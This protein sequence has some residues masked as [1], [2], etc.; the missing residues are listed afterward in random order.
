MQEAPQDI[1]KPAFRAILAYDPD[2]LFAYRSMVESIFRRE[3]PSKSKVAVLDSETSQQ[4]LS[5]GI[6]PDTWDASFTIRQNLAFRDTPA[7]RRFMETMGISDA[8]AETLTGVGT[9]EVGHWEFPKESG[10]G[11]PFDKPTYLTMFVEPVRGE[12]VRSGKFSAGALDEWSYR[13]A[14]AVTDIID[15]FHNATVLRERG[16]AYSGQTLFWYLQGESGRYSPEYSLFVKLNLA[17]FGN[18]KDNDLLRMFMHEAKDVGM[19]VKSLTRSFSPADENSLSPLLLRENWETIAR[20]YVREAL[21]YADLSDS[22]PKMAYSAGG[23]A[24]GQPESGQAGGQKHGGGKDGES[25][26]DGANAQ[27]GKVQLSKG[28]KEKIMGGRK[29][30]QGIPFYLDKTEA[31]DAYYS[32]LARRIPLKAA[33]KMPSAHLPLIPLTR[34]PYDPDVHDTRDISMGSVM[35]DRSRGIIA[36]SVTKS[37]MP[38]PIPVKREKKNLPDCMMVLLDSSGSMMDR[39]NTTIVPWGD[40]SFY[41]FGILAYYCQLRFFQSEHILHKMD[42]SGAIFSDRTLS[43]K[44]IDEV[45]RLIFNPMGGGTSL[46]MAKVMECLRSRHNILFSMISDGEIMNWHYIK[47]EFI[48][49]AKRNQFFM[50]QIGGMT[51]ASREMKAA[52][53][54]VYPVTG[55][56]DIVKLEVD[57]TAERYHAAIASGIAKEAKK[58]QS[59]VGK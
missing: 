19:S 34:E 8:I 48:A 33:G 46:D 42:L 22:S 23:G 59:M 21:K 32:A 53:L 25:A 27:G 44:G 40:E 54:A 41:H 20:L 26:E 16:D 47:D 36:H 13:F 10:F 7:L 5:A 12:L 18:Q 45:K 50:I 28:D 15:N 4:P 31:L 29:A 30:G 38:L 55:Y 6:D 3:G 24:M 9:H 52:G 49:L 56:K 51:R 39:G 14:N 35:L 1:Q 37:R 43:A 58:Y 17:L 57:L 11:C 2:R